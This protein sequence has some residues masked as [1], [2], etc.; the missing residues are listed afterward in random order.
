VVV[1]SPRELDKREEVGMRGEER[2]GRDER[3]LRLFLLGAS[4]RAIARSVG[5]RSPQSVC[6]IVRRELRSDDR[7][8][9]PATKFGR[10]IFVE[11][12]EALLRA[13]WPAAMAGDH[14]AGE[15]CLRLLSQQAQ[16]YG[17]EQ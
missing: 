15:E 3:V 16:F 5:L 17:L 1:I 14:D 8:F 9:S 11:R 4:Y 12:S 2:R 7:S 13:V 10:A 6:N